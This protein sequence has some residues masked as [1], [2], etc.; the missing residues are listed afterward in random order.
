MVP[1]ERAPRARSWWGFPLR[2]GSFIVCCLC[3]VVLAWVIFFS[4][5]DGPDLPRSG[6]IEQLVTDGTLVYRLSDVRCGLSSAPGAPREKP[7]NGQFCELTLEVRNPGDSTA[8]WSAALF[9][10]N[11]SY[12]VEWVL[13]KSSGHAVP[14]RVPATERHT[15]TLLF[16]IARNATPAQL[17]IGVDIS[18]DGKARIDL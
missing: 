7:E 14:D 12:G 16:D 1:T 3:L 2:L 13:T 4:G 17:E 5:D 10:G 6:G 8:S 9:A 15:G 11:A 18:G